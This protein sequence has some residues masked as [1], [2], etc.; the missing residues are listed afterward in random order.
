MKVEN[1]RI[2]KGNELSVILDYGN[3]ALADSFLNSKN[4]ITNEKK[5]F[6]NDDLGLMVTNK[7][8]KLL[9]LISQ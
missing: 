7:G 3:V 6:Q 1:C 8:R 5:Y 4:E 9:C 2:C